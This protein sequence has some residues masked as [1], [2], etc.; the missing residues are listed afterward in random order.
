MKRSEMQ[1]KKALASVLSGA[2]RS[3]RAL[4]AVTDTL[5]GGSLRMLQNKD[6]YYR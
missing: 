4:V 1:S 3:R 5:A 6:V 2:K